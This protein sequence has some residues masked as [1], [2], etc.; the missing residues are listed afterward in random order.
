MRLVKLE[1]VDHLFGESGFGYLVDLLD[2]DG[3]SGQ[4]FLRFDPTAI[5]LTSADGWSD[6][7]EI[8]RQGI[9]DLKETQR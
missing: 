3:S 9:A 2:D 5:D 8:L 6:F 1:R 7:G 4:M